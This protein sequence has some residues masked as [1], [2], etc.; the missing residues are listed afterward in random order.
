MRISCLFAALLLL[1]FAEAQTDPSP[2]PTDTLSPTAIPW[3]GCVDP[4]ED[5][6]GD[7]TVTIGKN[8]YVCL[9]IANTS[10]W[11][12]GVAYQRVSFSPKADQ[13]SRLTVPGCE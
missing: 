13:Y 9:N 12:S 8:T 4:N 10:D 1:S 7:A 3:G 2:A 6:D 5:A 11:T